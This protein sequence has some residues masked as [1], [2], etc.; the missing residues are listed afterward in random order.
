MFGLLPNTWLRQRELD[1]GIA[2]FTRQAK[3]FFGLSQLNGRFYQ[4]HTSGANFCSLKMTDQKG[5]NQWLPNFNV[6]AMI[7]QTGR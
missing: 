2:M 7:M 5:D 3:R 6:P 1:G 4:S